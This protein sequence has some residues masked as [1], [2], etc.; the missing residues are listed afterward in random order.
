M[1]TAINVIVCR[2]IRDNWMKSYSSTRMFARDHDIDEKTA[3]QIRD[4]DIKDY[5]ISLKTLERI[6]QSKEL[7]LSEFF[8]L[9]KR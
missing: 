2:Y 1:L 5:Q 8:T 9:I 6:C 7:K 4:I 3:R